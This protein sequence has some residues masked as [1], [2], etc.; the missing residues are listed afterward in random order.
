MQSSQQLPGDE[1]IRVLVADDTRIHTQLLADALR[2]DRQLEVI[3]PPPRS[4]DLV[5]TVKLH[6]VDVVVLSS[7]LDEEPL[8][9]FEVLRQLR[10]SNPGHSRHHAAG[11]FQEGNRSAGVSRRSAGDFQPARL[12]GD[13]FQMHPQRVRGPDLGEQSSRCRS[14]WKRWPPRP[15]CARWMPTA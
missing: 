8:R 13:A 6:R 15:W 5:E 10:A 4:R 9:G 7:N 1:M 14:R 3:S 12:R 2:R 11:L